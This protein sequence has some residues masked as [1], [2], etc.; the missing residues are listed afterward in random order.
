MLYTKQQQK[1]NCD[2]ISHIMPYYPRPK[3]Y[4]CNLS[5]CFLNHRSC[6]A[7]SSCCIVF[8]SHSSATEHWCNSSKTAVWGMAWLHLY[9]SYKVQVRVSQR[10]VC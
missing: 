8:T 3:K 4:L 2:I 7:S 1:I 10:Q 9:A 6:A 5:L